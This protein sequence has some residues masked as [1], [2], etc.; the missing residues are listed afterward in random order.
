MRR[1]KGFPSWS[2]AGWVGK[3]FWRSELTELLRDQSVRKALLSHF[4]TTIF[5]R[6]VM[7]KARSYE[8]VSDQEERGATARRVFVLGMSNV[9]TRGAFALPQNSK[10]SLD[11]PTYPSKARNDLLS[12]FTQVSG[13]PAEWPYLHFW[14]HSAHF[15]LSASTTSIPSISVD[16]YDFTL[17]DCRGHVCGAIPLALEWN[18]RVEELVEVLVLS[19]CTSSNHLEKERDRTMRAAQG[20]GYKPSLLNVMLIEWH[21]GGVAE[22]VA[23]GQIFRSALD[24]TFAPGIQWKEIT[25]W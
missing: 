2:W 9:Q 15:R 24:D 8:L 17:T 13:A 16:Y 12:A 7:S 19:T 25:L 11:H 4:P 23:V 20:R 22:R 14:T 18:A 10:D 5:F 21:D 3:V 1:R 6:Q